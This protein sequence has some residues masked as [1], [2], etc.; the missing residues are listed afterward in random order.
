MLTNRD[1]WFVGSDVLDEYC[2]LVGAS[3]SI[4]HRDTSRNDAL[5]PGMLIYQLAESAIRAD[6]DSRHLLSATFL[7]PLRSMT[8][9]TAEM[10]QGDDHSINIAVSPRGGAEA[11]LLRAELLA[12]LEPQRLRSAT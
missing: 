9:L 11:V 5:L 7:R 2:A 8:P 4:H 12:P 6:L 3:S 10:V 1:E